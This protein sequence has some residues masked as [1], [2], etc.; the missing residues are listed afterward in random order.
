[1]KSKNVLAHAKKYF[2]CDTLWGVP[3]ENGGSKGSVNGHWEMMALYTDGM[4]SAG[5]DKNEYISKFDTALL[6]DTN[7]YAE[8]NDD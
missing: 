6:K 3:L 4:V 7:W 2:G 1:M 5:G 8:I